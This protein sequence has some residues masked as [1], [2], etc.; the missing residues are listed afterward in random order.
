MNLVPHLLQGYDVAAT[1]EPPKDPSKRTS[2][3]GDSERIRESLGW[4]CGKGGFGCGSSIG[5]YEDTPFPEHRY[6][7]CP[8]VG[9]GHG[10]GLCYAKRIEHHLMKASAV[11]YNR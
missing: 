9:D 6:Q 3:I 10:S 8:G 4:G 11:A 1:P 5:K 7:S 2:G